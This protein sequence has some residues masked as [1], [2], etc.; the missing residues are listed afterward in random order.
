M[1]RFQDQC[2]LKGFSVVVKFY[3]MYDLKNINY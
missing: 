3:N 1:S 2:E